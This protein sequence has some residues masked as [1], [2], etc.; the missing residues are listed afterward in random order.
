MQPALWSESSFGGG[1]YNGN[2][3]SCESQHLHV[4]TAG[5]TEFKYAMSEWHYQTKNNH[6]DMHKNVKTN[7][8]EGW[9][10]NV[11]SSVINWLEYEALQCQWITVSDYQAAYNR[12]ETSVF[13]K[14]RNILYVK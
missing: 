5:M 8:V 13:T 6:S 12:T 1:D 4:S 9:E 7:A 11:L 14:Y 10:N 2:I 3:I